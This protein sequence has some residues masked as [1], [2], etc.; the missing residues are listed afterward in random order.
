M[1]YISVRGNL[2]SPHTQVYGLDPNQIDNISQILRPSGKNEDCNGI[3]YYN[4]VMEVINALEYTFGYEVISC[5]NSQYGEGYRITDL[6]IWTMGLQ[7]MDHKA[8]NGPQHRG[9]WRGDYNRR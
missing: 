2:G 9:G 3:S 7:N 8:H 6:M 4:S 1:S 5:T